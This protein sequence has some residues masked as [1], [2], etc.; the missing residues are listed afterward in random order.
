M[1]HD[2]DIAPWDCVGCGLALIVLFLIVIVAP[3]TIGW[4][5]GGII[6]AILGPFVAPL[7]C[8]GLYA[9]GRAFFKITGLV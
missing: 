3:I 7:V 9:L 8:A 2:S 1:S 5:A 4:Q 6:G